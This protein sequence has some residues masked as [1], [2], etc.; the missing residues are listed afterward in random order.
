[1]EL[2]GT[3]A[4][5]QNLIDML[6][7]TYQIVSCEPPQSTDMQILLMGVNAFVERK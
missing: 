3:A 1:M 2:D 7:R 6:E 5:I 4:D